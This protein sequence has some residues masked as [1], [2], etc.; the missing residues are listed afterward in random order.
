MQLIGIHMKL[1]FNIDII[2]KEVSKPNETLI[3]SNTVETPM[4]ICQNLTK[5]KSKASWFETAS[6]KQ[7]FRQNAL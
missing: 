1:S 7:Q 6:Y 4:V 3:K 5:A 2:F